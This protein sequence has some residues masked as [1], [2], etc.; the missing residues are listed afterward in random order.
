MSPSQFA[1]EMWC[2]HLTLQQK[3]SHSSSRSDVTA[4]RGER[5]PSQ[6]EPKRD[7]PFA[8]DVTSS[9]NY[10]RD[11]TSPIQSLTGML[12]H[13][14]TLTRDVTSPHQSLPGWWRRLITLYQGMWRHLITLFQGYDDTSSIFTWEVTSSHHSL[15]GIW[16]HLITLYQWC[17][18]TYSLFTKDVTSPYHSLLEIWRHLI[19]LQ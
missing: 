14:I 3:P 19:T 9:R 1:L 16:R 12:R 2:R 4:T 13:L 11:K 5:T 15:P 6:F 7:I 17:D 8:A 10:T 18:V